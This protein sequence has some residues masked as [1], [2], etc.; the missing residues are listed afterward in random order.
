M[1]ISPKYLMKLIEKISE[2]IWQD[3][4]S[5]KHV[6]YYIKK[7]HIVDQDWNS[8]D[9]NFKPLFEKINKLFYAN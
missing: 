2:I 5:Y 9:E 3:Y 8:R 6:E 4:Q 1:E 7:W